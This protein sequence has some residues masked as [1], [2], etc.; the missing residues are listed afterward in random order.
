MNFLNRKIQESFFAYWILHASLI[1]PSKLIQKVIKLSK[2]FQ[3]LS[4][5]NF[6]IPY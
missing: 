5:I 4:K 3:R 6:W 2:E 1:Q